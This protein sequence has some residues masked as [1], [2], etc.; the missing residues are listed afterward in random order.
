MCKDTGNG[1]ICHVRDHT[2]VVPAPQFIHLL[3]LKGQTRI[4][5]AG[6]LCGGGGEYF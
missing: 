2:D 1:E 4:D 6:G 3:Y 5:A